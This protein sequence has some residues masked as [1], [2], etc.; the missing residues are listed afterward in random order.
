MPSGGFYQG[1]WF[2]QNALNPNTPANKNT[3]NFP[4]EDQWIKESGNAEDL[5]VLP[6]NMSV[7][8]EEVQGGR[9]SWIE[10]TFA[11]TDSSFYV[12]PVRN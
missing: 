3:W 10:V 6:E 8:P 4:L 2:I 7:F 11:S 5:E 9:D 12:Q 1:S